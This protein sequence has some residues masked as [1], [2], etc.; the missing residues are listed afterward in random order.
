MTDFGASSPTPSVIAW[1]KGWESGGVVPRGRLASGGA[2]EAKECAHLGGGGVFKIVR[3]RLG[4]EV[5]RAQKALERAGVSPPPVQLVPG[6]LAAPDVDVIHVRYLKLAA[7]RRPEGLDDLEHVHVIHINPYDGVPGLRLRGLLLDA[8][9]FPT[10]EFGHAEA[11]WVGHLLE[12]DFRAAALVSV[13]PRGLADVL[14]DDVVAEDDADRLAVGERLAQGERRGDAALALLVRVVD[15]LEAEVAPVLEELEEVARGVS[16][17]DDHDVFY[18]CVDE[19][20]HGVVDHR[21]VVDGQKVFVRHRRQR[22]QSRPQPSG[23]YNAF[24]SVLQKP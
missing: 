14:L 4:H 2:V 22:A 20:L 8:Q 1:P 21:L 9:D 12:K 16:A 17:R 3:A 5:R 15:V 24:H 11:L 7:P 6:H 19:R 18:P 13:R 10:V 23:Q